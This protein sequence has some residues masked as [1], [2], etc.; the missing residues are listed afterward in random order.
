MKKITFL[1]TAMIAML[2]VI[3]SCE[4]Q[5]AEPIFDSSKTTA[6]AITEP[7]GDGNFMLIQDSADAVMTTFKWSA[8]GY[9]LPDLGS[10]VYS[11]QIDMADSSFANAKELANTTETSFSITV[12]EMNSLLLSMG[13]EPDVESVVEVRIMSFLNSNAGVSTVYSSP[14]RFSVTAYSGVV[15]AASLWV[16][17]NHQ[18]WNPAEAPQIWDAD[19]DNIFEGFV[20]FPEDGFD[21]EFKFTANPEWVDGENYGAGAEPGSLDNDSGAGNLIVPEFG[22]YYFTV[23]LNTLTWTY[24]AQSW[25]VIGS[26][27]LAG[28]WSEDVDIIPA[29]GGPLNVLETTIDVIAPPDGSELRFKFRANDGWDLNYGADEGSNVL[30]QGG[31]DIPMPDGPGNYTFIMNMS[32]PVFTYEFIKN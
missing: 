17:G 7:A 12:G 31:P 5:E 10:P 27:I 8:T 16:P 9:S 29:A 11:L 4:K 19:G 26:G 23:D 3:S 28:D 6:P 21:G 15:E 13:I 14:V 1:I 30:V 18:G 2:I 22:G 20:Y 25:G 24:E 32:Q